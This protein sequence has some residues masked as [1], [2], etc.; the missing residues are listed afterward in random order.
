MPN[1]ESLEARVVMTGGFLTGPNPGEPLEIA[2]DYLARH[3]DDYGLS[4]ADLGSLKVTDMYADSVGSKATHIYLRQGFEGLTVEGTE[5]GVHVMPDGSIIGITGSFVDGLSAQ[6][7]G[8]GPRPDLKATDALLAAAGALGLTPAA[9]PQ[10]T[11]AK[12]GVEQATTLSAPGIAIKPVTANLEYVAV[13]GGAKLAWEFVITTDVPQ[14]Q[15]YNVFVDATSGVMLSKHEWVDYASYNVYANP[16]ATPSYGPRQV[17][18]DPFDPVASPYGWHDTDGKAGAEFTDTRGNNVDAFQDLNANENPGNPSRARPDGGASLT[19]NFPIDFTQ[20]PTS[21]ADATTTNLF[22]LNNLLHDVHFKYGFTESAGNFQKTNYSGQGLG[23]DAVMA[24]DAYG[25]SQGATNNAFFGTPPDGSPGQMFMLLFDVTSPMR[26]SSLD[27]EIVIHEYGHGVSNRLTGGPAN[28]NAL[29]DLQSGGMGEGWSDWWAL[30]F[31]QGGTA[32]TRTTSRSVATYAVGEPL[33]GPGIRRFRYSHDM[34][35]NPLTL[36]SFN[37]GFPN[38]ESHNAGEIWCQVL[39]DMNI[40]L[41]EKHGYDQSLSKGYTGP[42]SAGNL[43]AL[44]LVMDGLKLQPANPTFIEAR[45]AILQA[46]M[47]LTG[48][49]NQVEIWTAFARRGFGLSASAGADAN[50]AV[51]TGATDTPPFASLSVSAPGGLSENQDLSNLL[52]ATLTDQDPLPASGYTAVV[53]WG[54]GTQSPGNIVA[55]TSGKFEIYAAN[56]TYQEGGKYDLTV[57]VD[58]PNVVKLVQT[59]T[60]SVTDLEIQATPGQLPASLAEGEGFTGDVATF[61]DTDPDLLAA[62]SYSVTVQW[63]DDGTTSPGVVTAVPGEPNT[64]VVSSSHVFAGGVSDVVVTITGP[65]GGKASA[66]IHVDVTDSELTIHEAFPVEAVEGVPYTQALVRFTD[67]DPRHPPATNYTA[68]I[69]WGDGSPT[70][71]GTIESDFVNGGFVVKGSHAYDFSATPRQFKVT[72]RNKTGNNTATDDGVVNVEDSPITASGY[73]RTVTEGVTF[74]HLLVSFKDTDPRPHPTSRY[75]ATI[76]WKDGS[77]QTSTDPSGAVRVIVNTDGGFF[78]KASHAYRLPGTYAY[79]ATVSDALGESETT[80]IGTLIV[81][82]APITAQIEADAAPKEGQVF[83]GVI[84]SFATPNTLIGPNSFK[85][86]IF[87]GDGT[88]TEGAEVTKDPKT[89]RFL[90]SGSKVYS[91]V[92]NYAVTVLIDA[93][94]DQQ[95]GAIGTVTVGDAPLTAQGASGLSLVSKTRV[96]DLLVASFVDADPT[97][98]IGDFSAI[99]A[100]GDGTRSNGTI[101]ANGRGGFDVLGSHAYPRSGDFPIGVTITSSGGSGASAGTG[102]KVSSKVF[103]LDGS[104]VSAGTPGTTNTA[105]PV[106]AGHAEPGA[107]VSLFAVQS[108]TGS[109]IPIGSTTADAAGAW[110]AQASRLGDGSYS[111]VASAVDGSGDLSSPA[112]LLHPTPSVGPLVVDTQGPQVRNVDVDPRTGQVRVTLAD[113]GTGLALGGLNNAANFALGVVGG[114]TT[115]MLR[116]SGVTLSPSAPNGHLSATLAFSGL[117]RLQR[118]SYVLSISAPGV[119]DQAGN[120]LD[121]RYYVPFPGLYSQP[122]QNFVA[123]FSSNGR[124]ASPLAQYIPPAEIAA[125]QRFSQRILGRVR[126]RRVGRG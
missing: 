1:L 77:T 52:V 117:T 74:D 79:E 2:M 61:H 116:V 105:T 20:A 27:G 23:D 37:G 86:T 118:G 16:N 11:E 72:V 46:D 10:V 39:W 88:A 101:R 68:Q 82:P 85:A 111:I 125:A 35:V 113:G 48:G 22:Y 84:A 87:W 49:E 62:E 60:V 54:D 41:V 8:Q 34:V 56:K 55:T 114:G 29:D 92:G 98:N 71:S 7:T 108:G 43:L 89:G 69:E 123:Q 109:M 9:A 31:T 32:P 78:V 119:T 81:P 97:P 53:D 38:N 15:M 106:F 26:S 90:V 122:G 4:P 30:M 45:D 5:M 18:V 33:S 6:A 121:E 67:A 36:N 12:G 51:V 70:T 40:L 50:S 124:R 76:N 102:A 75:H 93:P 63:G 66:I 65:G 17:L 110:A 14:Y 96:D 42:G 107:K 83:G 99:I 13:P 115:R 103:T 24:M 57:S 21:Y 112:T 19:F 3:G 58:K 95:A 44:Q 47:A 100:W 28:A 120:A 64:F 126:T 73:E 94:G 25:F 91:D 104:V 59:K 80:V